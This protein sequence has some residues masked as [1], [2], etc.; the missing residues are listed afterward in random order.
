M[1]VIN[2]TIQAG[3]LSKSHGYGGEIRALLKDNVRLIKKFPSFLFLKINNKLVPFYIEKVEVLNQNTF[4]I[5]LEDVGSKEEASLYTGEMF[6][7]ENKYCKS[8]NNFDPEV[9]IHYTVFNQ[10]GISRGIIKDVID[11]PG[12]YLLELD[13]GSLLPLHNELILEINESEKKIKLIIAEGL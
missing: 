7:L 1:L 4:L 9:L 13:D 6:Y 12:H 10:D 5:K 8:A 2:N 11:N 3:F